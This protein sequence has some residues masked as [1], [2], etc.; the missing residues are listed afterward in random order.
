[1]LPIVRE[2]LPRATVNSL[3]LNRNVVCGKHRDAKNSTAQSHILFFG[4]YA[5][6]ELCFETGEVLSQRDV[7]HGCNGRCH[8][9]EQ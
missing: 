9:L 1:M 8:A 4:E 3:Q 2:M 7:W 6:G 5:G